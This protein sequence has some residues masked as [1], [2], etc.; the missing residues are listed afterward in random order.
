MSFKAFSFLYN[1]ASRQKIA[2]DVADPEQRHYLVE[3]QIRHGIPLQLRAMREGHGWTQATLAEKL[4][5]TQNAIS[6]LE[7]PRTGKPTITTLERIAQAF[8]VALIVKF[9]PFSEFIDSLS[10]LSD[11]SVSVPSYE[12]EEKE[13]EIK[14]ETLGCLWRNVGTAQ[15]M[16]TTEWNAYYTGNGG[17]TYNNVTD[18]AKGNKSNIVDISLYQGNSVVLDDRSFYVEPKRT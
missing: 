10:E 2:K 15:T 1:T 4:G 8:D 13:K 16:M 3:A 11:K 7:N 14:A 17:M 9:A 18:Q 12:D 5:T 6:R